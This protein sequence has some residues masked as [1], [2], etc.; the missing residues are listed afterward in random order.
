MTEA[1]EQEEDFGRKKGRKKAGEAENLEG[2]EG[3]G[4]GVGRKKSTK[5]KSNGKKGNG[6]GDKEADREIN[7]GFGSM[8]AAKIK[9]H[10]N[11]KSDRFDD[12]DPEKG[13]EALGFSSKVTRA[14]EEEEFD[15]ASTRGNKSKAKIKEKA[16]NGKGEEEEE[17]PATP[18]PKHASGI[19]D[20][21]PVAV[22]VVARLERLRAH[23][24]AKKLF[25]CTLDIGVSQ[26]SLQVV[27][28]GTNLREG[29]CTVLAPVGSTIKTPEGPM[30]IKPVNLRGFESQGM[31]CGEG[32]LGL[33]APGTRFSA[34]VVELAAGLKL[35][36]PFEIPMFHD[37]K[38]KTAADW[39]AAL[40]AECSINNKLACAERWCAEKGVRTSAQL[41]DAVMAKE[42][43][44]ALVL[45]PAKENF[46]LKRLASRQ[47][48]GSDVPK[49][50]HA[51]IMSSTLSAAL[52]VDN[53]EEEGAEAQ[54][55]ASSAAEIFEWLL[56]LEIP[57]TA[58]A[59][60]A[61][62]LCARFHTDLEEL[63]AAEADITT[64]DGLNLKRGHAML[65]LHEL[66][67]AKVPQVP[68]LFVEVARWFEGLEFREVHTP[69]YVAALAA[70]GL[71]NCK[72]I[73]R[74]LEVGVL[75]ASKLATLGMLR[76]HVLSLLHEFRNL[77]LPSA[78]DVGS[79][80]L[81]FRFG[82]TR[83][84][85]RGPAALTFPPDEMLPIFPFNKMTKSAMRVPAPAWEETAEEETEFSFGTTM[86]K[87]KKKTKQTS[88]MSAVEEGVAEFDFGAKPKK[89]KKLEERAAAEEE[90]SFSF[91]PVVERVAVYPKQ[92]MHWLKSGGEGDDG[93]TDF[94]IGLHKG[95]W[96]TSK[97]KQ[98]DK[99]DKTKL[100][101]TE[102]LEA[103]R[104]KEAAEITALLAE[105]DEPKVVGDRIKFSLG[106][107]RQQE[108]DEGEDRAAAMAHAQ[109]ASV[110][111]V[112][113]VRIDTQEN[114]GDCG[115][116]TEDSVLI[117]DAVPE[118]V[119][120]EDDTIKAL[121]I[122]TGKKGKK[123]KKKRQQRGGAGAAAD[124]D[125]EMALLDAAMAENQ[126]AKA[127]SDGMAEEFKDT[128]VLDEGTLEGAESCED[129]KLTKAQK[130][131]L[132]A[133]AKKAAIGLVDEG[134][135]G[136]RKKDDRKKP[137]SKL[138]CMLREEQERRTLEEAALTLAAE[139]TEEAQHLFKSLNVLA[140]GE[141][142]LRRL[143]SAEVSGEVDQLGARA[144][145]AVAE[146]PQFEKVLS[147]AAAVRELQAA[148]KRY[149]DTEEKRR[150]RREKEKER[151]ERLRDEGKLIS[152]TE[153]AKR[154]KQEAYLQ[155]L[156][157][158]SGVLPS[159]GNEG[160][161]EKKKRVSNRIPPRP[162]LAAA[163]PP[164][165]LMGP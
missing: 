6:N 33:L 142:A 109:G 129:G 63:Q 83:T 162:S 11:G 108:A 98:K 47:L 130:K 134:D 164:G 89:K 72:A 111:P 41:V 140:L 94:E 80:T 35:G 143:D 30:A 64:L 110:A 106:M 105:L 60:Y 22:P 36:I 76:G 7:G 29:M 69:R 32:E 70:E 28:G 128:K 121:G 57:R 68:E 42:F 160:G 139:L 85:L 118:M 75:S 107:I 91:A 2:E 3:G 123:E 9:G 19:V 148:M 87:L 151:K 38:V 48:S 31:L 5:S 39:L 73:K 23:P 146:Y 132:K 55:L 122:K 74:A 154:V 155:S 163:V 62:Q 101:I 20:K 99:K 13:D 49:S 117:L 147:V 114:S 24:G 81:A 82:T 156:K 66:R 26:P 25:V 59:A 165:S 43:A 4:G 112:T 88:E 51:K 46:L 149:L 54:V 27:C 152:A 144:Q 17:A 1:Q 61:S 50:Q 86:A 44:Q 78:V 12:D 10:D 67:L 150:L 103:Q 45:K 161:E 84:R 119:A 100:P 15:F 53:D 136:G 79:E 102:E 135:E 157:E 97:E 137:S 93:G 21:P 77:A 126:V 141:K 40:L 52:G 37:A 104:A 90:A 125:D 34:E 124:E 58:A 115:Y 113:N 145:R 158:S 116:A 159:T 133:K 65:L 138:A 153:R 127:E 120:L 96:P 18:A 8:T 71:Q 92:Q 56:K 131:K 95:G 16:K 14:K